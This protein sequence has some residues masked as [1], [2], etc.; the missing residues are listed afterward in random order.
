MWITRSSHPFRCVGRSSVR[1]Q[2]GPGVRHIRV[3]GEPSHFGSA[4]QPGGRSGPAAGVVSIGSGSVHV[5]ADASP[6]LAYR[7]GLVAVQQVSG[8]P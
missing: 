7:I 3:S 6:V 8:G 2:G 4:A 1:A 5:M